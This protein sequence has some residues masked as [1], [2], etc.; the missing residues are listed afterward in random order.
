MIGQLILCASQIAGIAGE[1]LHDVFKSRVLVIRGIMRQMIAISIS[2]KI[3]A[4]RRLHSMQ[5]QIYNSWMPICLEEGVDMQNDFTR[6][7]AKA[8]ACSYI[9]LSLL[10]R[11]DQKEPGLIDDLLAGAK[12]DFEASQ[13]QDDLPAPVPM[14]FKEAIAFL[15]RANA[16][17][18][19]M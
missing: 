12:G 17:K 18:Q 15:T 9:L 1:H 8:Q 13:S 14:I 5:K 2:Y 3:V 11:M 6:M 19:N 10:Q 16:Y 7:D 4:E